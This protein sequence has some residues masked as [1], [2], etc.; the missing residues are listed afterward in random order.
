RDTPIFGSP[1]LSGRAQGQKISFHFCN[2]DP[3]NKGP[4]N[5]LFS[6]ILEL[7]I[8]AWPIFTFFG[9]QASRVRKTQSLAP[10][11]KIRADAP[12]LPSLFGGT[13][14]YAGSLQPESVL[15]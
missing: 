6:T 11:S 15:A 14:R 3:D 12:I 7:S 10:A 8:P 9:S 4:R 5:R 13:F 2:A 1:A